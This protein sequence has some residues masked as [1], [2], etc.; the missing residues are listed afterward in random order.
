MDGS[1][2]LIT[3]TNP[4]QALE[5]A[6]VFENGLKNAWVSNQRRQLEHMHEEIQGG[7]KQRARQGTMAA[8]TRVVECTATF[9]I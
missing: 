9:C 6:E 5:V 3:F 7:Q 8:I 1:S 4:T 2:I